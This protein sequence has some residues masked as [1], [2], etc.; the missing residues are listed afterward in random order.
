MRR[1]VIGDIHGCYS[2]FLEALNNAGF[3][4]E[5]DMLYSLGDLCDRGKQNREVVDYLMNLPHF[6][7]V[8]GNHDIWLFS[9][10]QDR[11]K[12]R[13]MWG[14]EISC[15]MHNGGDSTQN[16]F[17]GCTEE[18]LLRYEDF[19]GKFQYKIELDNAVLMHNPLFKDILEDD[20]EV[21]L[22]NCQN[23]CLVNDPVYDIF[24]WDR[25]VA[26]DLERGWGERFVRQDKKLIIC[27]HTPFEE[28]MHSDKLGVTCIDTGS[29][30]GVKF[31]AEACGWSHDGKITVM[32]IDSGEIWQNSN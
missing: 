25:S 13:M 3:D 16:A 26:R 20:S 11:L 2:K 6:R 15:W 27:G 31:P 28:V 24:V 32:D 17:S 12:K 23:K 4:P 10:I 30:I 18:E 5:E 9:Y 14:D 21:T 19:L 29:F 1:L 8:F 22:E 7:A